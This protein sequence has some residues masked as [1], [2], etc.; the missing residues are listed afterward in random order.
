MKRICGL[1]LALALLLS[2]LAPAAAESA[3]DEAKLLCLNIGKAD[4]LLLFYGETRWLIDAGY[5]QTWPALRTALAEYGV[6]HLDGVFLTHCHKDHSGGLMP[7]AQSDLPVSA[8]YASSIWYDVKKGK[9]PAALAAQARGEEVTWLNAGD[10][11]PAGGGASL[12]VLGPAAVN[13]DNENNNS[14]V[15]FFSSPAGSILLCGDMKSDEEADLLYE[16]TIP[17]CALLKVGHHGDSGATTDAFLAKARPQAAVI[18]TSSA[19]EADTPDPGTLRRLKKIG[20]AVYVTQDFRDAVL[21]TLSGGK[22]TRAEDVR[23]QSAPPRA[24][25][26]TLAVDFVTDTAT[27]RNMTEAPLSLDGYTLYSTKGDETIRLED[28]TLAPGGVWV[29]A[30][31]HSSS[32]ADQ[33]WE[34]EEYVWH[35]KKKDIGILYDPWG[36]PVACAD[37]GLDD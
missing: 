14:L 16:G 37:N 4:C 33:K 17:P 10:V 29:I 8:W 34:G 7:L 6:D 20:S 21:F 30:G 18:S 22:V 26:I 12:T 13:E 19:E 27:L 9:H 3:G 25:G 28:V 31:M 11:I 5:E 2:M 36:R 23:W 24:E 35:N 15:L 1:L 32:P